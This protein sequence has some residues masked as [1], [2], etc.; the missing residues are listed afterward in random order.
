M[1]IDASTVDQ[2]PVKSGDK[3]VQILLGAVENLEQSTDER[4]AKKYSSD[5]LLKIEAMNSMRYPDAYK[6]EIKNNL[7]ELIRKAEK[8]IKDKKL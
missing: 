1:A 2:V 4:A 7:K 8:L 3:T 5:A 6:K